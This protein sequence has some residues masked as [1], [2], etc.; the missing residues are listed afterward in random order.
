MKKTILFGLFV[1]LGCGKIF[2]QP[3]QPPDTNYVGGF[4][5]KWSVRIYS[6]YK[7]NY[8]YLF[9]SNWNNRV[10]FIPETKV[11]AGL[12]ISY[13]DLAIDIGLDVYKSSLVA[14]QHTTGFNFIGSMYS[15]QNV[16]DI[17]FQI[18]NGFTET[19]IVEGKDVRI[20]RNDVNVF[21]FGINYN[22]LFN[23]RHYSFNSSFIGTKIQKR[24][25]GSPM[26]GAFFSDINITAHDSIIPSDFVPIFNTDVVASQ[27]S[28]FSGGLTAG[29]AYTWVLPYH[30]LITLSLTPGISFSLGEAQVDSLNLLENLQVVTPKLVTRDAIGYSGKRAYVVLTYGLDMNMANLGGK[31][32]LL[33]TP[34]KVKLALGWRIY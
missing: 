10:S 33:Y 7:T 5:S 14:D 15:N 26:V 30:F 9:N 28:V 13:R 17:T 19:S 16:A 20:A 29:Y 34:Q 6:A 4:S 12:G 27:A 11:A 32:L 18:N 24:S 1:V 22:Y 2:S 3:L 21:N 31:N 8:F 23:Y 25:A